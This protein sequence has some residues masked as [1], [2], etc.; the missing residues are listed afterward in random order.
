M[1]DADRRKRLA[2]R[3]THRG[4]RE[5]DLLFSAFVAKHMDQLN[6]QDLDALDVILQESDHDIL[7]WLSKDKQAPDHCQS[8]VFD[9]LKTLSLKPEDYSR[10]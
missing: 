4:I 3:A 2:F 5:M 10:A 9:L 6:S 7:H 8:R 1:N